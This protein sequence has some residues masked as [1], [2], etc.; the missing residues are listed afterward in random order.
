MGRRGQKSTLLLWSHSPAVGLLTDRTAASLQ[1]IMYAHRQL[2]RQ[3]CNCWKKEQGSGP[4]DSS[5]FSYVTNWR[6]LS[7]RLYVHRRTARLWNTAPVFRHSWGFGLSK[8]QAMGLFQVGGGTYPWRNDLS[9]INWMQLSPTVLCWSP[10]AVNTMRIHRSER[11]N[12]MAMFHLN[13][14]AAS[15]TTVLIV[16]FKVVTIG[17]SAIDGGHSE[18][19]LSLNKNNINV[20]SENS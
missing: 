9:K 11:N 8:D 19:V 16:K 12:L 13:H 4:A 14:A 5:T 7:I 10:Q 1:G 2:R 3:D 18:R 15:Q 17:W 20:F 6:K